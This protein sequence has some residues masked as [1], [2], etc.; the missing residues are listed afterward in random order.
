MLRNFCEQAQSS[1][2]LW[3]ISFSV[4]FA[5]TNRVT[6][7]ESGSI[8]YHASSNCERNTSL[9][10]NSSESKAIC[11]STDE[12]IANWGGSSAGNLSNNDIAGTPG[13]LIG[14]RFSTVS[15]YS[16]RSDLASRVYLLVVV[17][18]LCPVCRGHPNSVGES[19]PVT[20]SL[21]QGSE[22]S[23]VGGLHE[24]SGARC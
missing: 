5:L 11:P 3:L 13:W 19:D 17:L 6:E 9:R 8:E 14:A 2:A 23:R 15:Y 10:L 24:C 4:S 16:I 7:T 22:T 12:L 1:E 21:E 20:V 18:N